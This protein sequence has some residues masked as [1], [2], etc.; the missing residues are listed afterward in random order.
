M[1]RRERSSSSIAADTDNTIESSDD[2]FSD[3]S[4]GGRQSVGSTASIPVTRVER[5]DDQ[6]S[7]GEVPG[8]AAY[9]QR[10]QDAVPDEVEIVPPGQRSRSSSL[11]V[12]GGRPS[13]PRSPG[14][15]PIPRTI[16]EK[17]E[18]D[19]PS[20]GEVPGTAAFDMRRADA[21][22][23]EVVTSADDTR[24]TL[25]GKPPTP[26]AAGPCLTAEGEPIANHRSRSPSISDARLFTG[27]EISGGKD[28]PGV[29]GQEVE[30]ED[31]NGVVQDGEEEDEDEGDGIERHQAQATERGQEEQ[32]G[33][34]QGDDDFG[35]DFDD[36]EEG[37]GGDDEDDFG[38]FG[39]AADE[40]P[41]PIASEVRS[42]PIPPSD[43]LS[44]LVCSRYSVCD[45]VLPLT[46]HKPPIDLQDLDSLFDIKGSLSAYLGEL[47]PDT[48]VE[49]LPFQNT[50]PPVPEPL[51]SDRSASLWSQLVAPPPLQ[52]PN[53]IRSRI[54]R[55][56]LVSLGV[57]VD[58]DEILPASKQKKL[59]LPSIHLDVD[60]PRES[61]NLSRVKKQDASTTSVNSTAERSAD[62]SNEERK[63]TGAEKVGGPSPPLFDTNAASLLCSTTEAA[64]K[65]LSDDEL[66]THVT[67]LEELT[68]KAGEVLDYWV[69][70][71]DSAVGDKEAFEGVIENLVG[72][73]KKSKQKR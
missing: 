58:L 37:G 60:S 47:F 55:L 20:H 28:A 38:D 66:R 44:H 2:H 63:K 24:A 21:Q 1:V 18:P 29:G 39:E 53:W 10:T 54:R 72:F 12:G 13:T 73:V 15:T 40:E 50:S 68:E 42:V 67:R 52:P 45:K 71:K 62:P 19:H 3:A 31:A 69:K 14:G 27:P 34:E 23:D 41:T 64:L 5:V 59:V 25:Q 17:V 33:T 6:P 49:S 30:G 32:Q 11:Q 48:D 56:F 8:T 70:R 16:V 9:K 61:T 46:V 43:P 4:E 51:L 7:H 35:D 36:F 22:P 26:T 57:P 65:N